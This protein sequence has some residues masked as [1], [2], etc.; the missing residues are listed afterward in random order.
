MKLLQ[1]YDGL[2]RRNRLDLSVPDDIT[3]NLAPQITL[4][5]YQIQ[6][7]A[8][9]RD[10][11]DDD[12]RILPVQLLFEMATGSG[13][14]PCMVAM[15][16]DLYIRGYRNF[17][18]FVNSTQIVEKTKANFLDAASLKHLFADRIRIEGRHVPVR[19][20]ANFD[21]SHPD[22]I[23]IH[24]TTIHGLH[25]RMLRPRENDMTPEDFEETRVV[26]ISDEAHHMSAETKV[27][28]KLT[29]VEREA[30]QSWEATVRKIM[31]RNPENILLEF[32]ATADLENPVIQQKYDDRLIYRYDLRHFRAD[33]YSKD[34]E[35]RQASLPP[36]E[37]MLQAAVLS[38]YRRKI[39]ESNGI[40]C[41]PVILMK[42]SKIADSKVN[43]IL[44]QDMI[45]KLDGA[46]IRA[47]LTASQGDETLELAFDFI[48]AN[49]GMDPDDFA[50]ELRLD[51]AP[52][53]IVN[54]NDPKDLEARQIL[55]NT[56]EDR[57]NEIRVIFAVDKL[58]EGWDVLN[59]FDIV[60]LYDKR[61][62]KGDKVGKTTM[63]E[64]QLI[65]RGARYFPFGA[66]GD[67]ESPRD[68]RKFDGD[69]EN[70]LRILE[71]IHYHCSHNPRYIDDIKKALRNAGMIDDT[72]RKVTLRV[73]D[74]FKQTDFYRTGHV[75]MNDRRAN[76]REEIHALADY[77]PDQG[78]A[79]PVLMSGRV[80]ESGAF[81][82]GRGVDTGAGE[83]GTRV[84]LLS[85][86]GD[87]LLRFAMDG[88]PFFR[89]EDL[90]T[91][92]PGLGARDRFITA[93]E[94]L[95]GVTVT[96]R[97]VPERIN[98]LSSQDRIDIARF[99]LEKVEAAIKATRVD[100]I[101]TRDFVPKLLGK[102]LVDKSLKIGIEGERGRSWSESEIE[103]ID[104]IDLHAEDWHVF[105]DSYGTDQEKYL[106]RFMHD[107]RDQLR[108]RF[109]EFYLV[110]NEKM[111]T[112]YTFAEGRAF[113]PDFILFL[114]KVNDDEVNTIQVFVEPKGRHLI[115]EDRWK[116]DFLDEIA[117]DHKLA[118]L[119]VGKAY[120]IR[121]LPFFNDAA[122]HATRFATEFEGLLE[123]ASV[124]AAS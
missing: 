63:S 35:L 37:R 51:F 89:F 106:I 47:L 38:Q 68:R 84:L 22:A 93:P 82:A 75:W 69:V 119:F 28:D 17:L 25:A 58:N 76:L 120:T 67:D 16:L 88:M 118:T 20:V 73:K 23:N 30:R 53:K 36:V 29:A 45:A 15:M 57:N 71:Q 61:D 49:R 107:H 62:G 111:V 43:E 114:R 26:L 79:Y 124:A 48:L 60:R 40:R 59:L 52:E 10:Y 80:L 66:L 115:A 83:R 3:G 109:E 33:G 70:P 9:F 27:L 122:T 13:K 39:A 91:L 44:F 102:I 24:F 21:E 41:K 2:V 31:E 113:E 12:Q 74:S 110:R 56:L 54:V 5:P 95:A 77:M 1:D 100:H 117:R 96:L 121:G 34:I 18:F 64:A 46:R 101:G 8:R 87:D 6:A 78:L 19:A 105:E 116:E 7:V 98:S 97:G 65:G 72:A 86:L 55:L 85:E 4:R 81:D 11:M 99:V 92:F 94:F 103:G 14:T 50:Q 112:I 42:S 32:T 104:H 123:P 90:E 108:D